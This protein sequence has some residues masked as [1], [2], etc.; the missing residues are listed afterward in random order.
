MAETA[1]NGTTTRRNGALPENLFLELG[2]TGLRQSGGFLQEEYVR[3]LSGS[4]GIRTYKRMAN[5]DILGAILF[6]NE[7]LLRQVPWTV[8]PADETPLAAEHAAWLDGALMHDMS[9]SWDM[10]LSDCLSFQIYGWAWH[11]VVY[12][13]RLGSVPPSGY[14]PDDPA[15]SWWAPSTYDDGLI[16]WAKWPIRSQD[17][18][19]RWEMA[20]GGEVRA[21]VQQDPYAAKT[22]TIPKAKALL[23][24]LFSAKNSPE[25]RSLLRHSYD[26]WYFKSHIRRIEGIGIERDLAGLFHAQIPPQYMAADASEQEKAILAA[27]KTIGR[28]IHRDEQEFLL[29]PLAYDENGHEL[30]KFGL[31]TTGGQ[32][33]F[34]TTAILQRYDT[35]MLQSCLANILMLGMINVGTQALGGELGELY[36][37]SLTTILDSIAEVVNLDAIPQLWA[38]NALPP[39]TQPLLTHGKVTKVDFDKFTQGLLRL[40]QAGIILS[41]ADEAHIRM[42]LD[43]PAMVAEEEL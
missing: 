29:T 37:M 3:D 30:F 38:L 22:A 13:R 7:M 28:N 31:M 39:E 34:D 5:D 9:Q 16:G 11:E 33:Q 23:F 26:S 41:E 15:W 24:R 32:R 20:H 4:R 1:R 36:S 2:T 18:L 27:I 12:K 21:M 25:G 6:A 43:F 19:L 10:F 8:Q 17:T 35:R 40:S 14:V 42:E